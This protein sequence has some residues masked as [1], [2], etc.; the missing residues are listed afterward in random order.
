LIPLIIFRFVI[1][2]HCL[3]ADNSSMW[4][5][6]IKSFFG[7]LPTWVGVVG[8]LL[9]FAAGL[10][11]YRQAQ[12]WKRAEFAAAEVA[13]FFA[14][15]KVQTALLLLDYSSIRLAPNGSRVASRNAGE[16]YNDNI[17]IQ[18]L[19]L[20]TEFKNETETLT[21][22]EM[23][24]REA[25]DAFLTGLEDMHQFIAAELLSPDDLRP[26][27]SYWL[28]VMADPR[29]QWKPQIFYTMMHR[30]IKGYSYHGVEQLLREILA[31]NLTENV[32]PRPEAAEQIMPR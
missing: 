22:Q 31:L 12:R 2:N 4:I 16:V 11:Q 1:A 30:F 26:Y 14:T 10:L 21:F 6:A 20:H 18:S 23:V 7:D 25:F 29:S 17:C 9:G 32:I 3:D 27:L 15:P 5:L 19:Q 24:A 13:R 28:G 8:G